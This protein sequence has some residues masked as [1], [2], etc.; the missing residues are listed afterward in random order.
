MTQVDAISLDW[1]ISM[2]SARRIVGK[3]KVLAGNIDPSLLL[4]GTQEDIRSVVHGC[5]VQAGKRKHVLNVGHG[6]EIGTSADAVQCLVD[7]AKE[8]CCK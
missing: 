1:H 2:Q 4:H 5:I 7:A 3:N 6:V 8:I